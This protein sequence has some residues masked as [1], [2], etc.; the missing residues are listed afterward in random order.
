[1]NIN[2]LTLIEKKFISKAFVRGGI[3][4]LK[5]DIAIDF[6]NECRQNK[7]RIWGID[8]FFLT[9]D[10]TQ[11]S[12]EHSITFDE[13]SILDESFYDMAVKFVKS[14]SSLTNVYFEVVPDKSN[15]P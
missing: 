4:F 12:L 11:P 15:T 8:T 7:I 3:L 13:D 2:H 9:A 6:I 10:T 1:M 14:K 5:S